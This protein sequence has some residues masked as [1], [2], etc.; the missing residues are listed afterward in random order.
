MSPALASLA[1]RTPAGAIG[2]VLATAFW[3]GGVAARGLL[4]ALEL[5][6]PSRHRLERP[7]QL[8]DPGL[9]PCEL[10][11]QIRRLIAEGLLVGRSIASPSGRA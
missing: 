1:R 9:L 7:L 6:Q 5:I 3:P 8:L 11:F 10:L 4:R 2:V